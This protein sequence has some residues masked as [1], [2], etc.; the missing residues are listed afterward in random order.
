MPT[1]KPSATPSAEEKA[2]AEAKAAEKKAAEDKSAADAAIAKINAL[3]SSAGVSDK[4]AVEAARKAYNA[5]TEDQ[6]QLV[7]ADVVRKLTGAETKVTAAVKA[8]AK[9]IK[10][11]KCKITVKAKV[12]TGKPL[13]PAV[14]VKYKG[15]ALKKGTDYTV[16]YKN[17]KAIGKA[18]VVVKGKGKYTGTVKKAFRINPK[19]VK[20]LMLKAGLKQITVSWKKD[21]TVTGYEIQYALNKSFKG[22]KKVTIKKAATVKTVIK[23]LKAKKLYYVRIRGYKTVKKV[24]YVSAWSKVLKVTTKK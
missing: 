1:V 16:S 9:K 6:K 15:K 13:K 21:K 11:S 14:T 10:L 5:L 17:N 12:Y 22:A 8:A 18:T 7:S 4:A 20:G 2:A 23:K 24:K 3:P 19:A